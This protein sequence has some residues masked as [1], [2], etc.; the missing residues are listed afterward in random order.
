M[1]GCA[2]RQHHRRDCARWGRT[3]RNAMRTPLIRVDGTG[4]RGINHHYWR[5]HA[6]DFHI[7]QFAKALIGFMTQASRGQFALSS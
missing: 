2:R 7:S 3:R 6:A 4:W 5:Q 1:R